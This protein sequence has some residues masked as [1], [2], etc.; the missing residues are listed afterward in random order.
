MAAP[1][2]VCKQEMPVDGGFATRAAGDMVRRAAPRPTCI[3]QAPH[4]PA[5][6]T[7]QGPASHGRS[8]CVMSGRS[9]TS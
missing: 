1:G 5:Q 6:C 9:V 8:S 4:P 3:P 7:G 2:A